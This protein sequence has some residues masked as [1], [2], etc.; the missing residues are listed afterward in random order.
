MNE[1]ELWNV[2][3][4]VIDQAIRRLPDE[5]SIKIELRGGN[6]RPYVILH[7]DTGDCCIDGDG[8]NDGET[9]IDC[10]GRLVLAA[11]REAG[12]T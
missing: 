11:E 6:V 2:P 10:I 7:D 1:W 3:G 5:W 12:D 8:P 4:E 9:L